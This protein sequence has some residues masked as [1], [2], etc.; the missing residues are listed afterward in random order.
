MIG[1]V[2]INGQAEMGFLLGF[3]LMS[4]NGRWGSDQWEGFN[5]VVILIRWVQYEG[6]TDTFGMTLGSDRC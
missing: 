5:A 1:E 4:R 2:I 6:W 3:G